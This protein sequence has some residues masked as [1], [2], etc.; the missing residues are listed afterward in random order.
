MRGGLSAATGVILLAAAAMGATPAMAQSNTDVL[1]DFLACDAIDAPADRLTCFETTLKLYKIRYGLLRSDPESLARSDRARPDRSLGA[2]RGRRAG[3]PG[4][5]PRGEVG[6][7]ALPPLGGRSAARSEDREADD[8]DSTAPRGSRVS[9]G[10]R[11]T[12]GRE[13]T[14]AA[15]VEDLPVPLETEITGYNGDDRGRFKL[16]IAE[17]WV[18]EDAGGP[19]FSEDPTGKTITLTKNFLGNWRMQVPGESQQVWVK[20]A[21]Q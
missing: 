8:G 4:A 3:Q 5:V 20:P 12:R 15:T 10:D 14:R 1:S 16:R 2:D 21:D 17:G 13:V 7:G 19:G 11:V 6:S 9:P 18:F